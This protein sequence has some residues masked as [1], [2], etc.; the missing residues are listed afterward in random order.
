MSTACNVRKKER[1]FCM[2]K[3]TFSIEDILSD[4]TFFESISRSTE[5][6]VSECCNVFSVIKKARK[7]R[8]VFGQY[9][10]RTGPVVQ[11]KQE[12]TRREKEQGCF[13]IHL[14]SKICL[15]TN[16]HRYY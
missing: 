6:C 7:R 15:F 5:N 9:Y 11:E 10:K 8:T 13:Q 12:S 3:I 4:K 14:P 16:E 1:I 2:K